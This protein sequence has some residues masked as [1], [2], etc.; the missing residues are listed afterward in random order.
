MPHDYARWKLPLIAQY[1]GLSHFL[2]TQSFQSGI[3]A[4]ELVSG[5]TLDIL[6]QRR[7][8]PYGLVVFN[9]AVN[10]TQIPNPPVLYGQG[11]AAGANATLISV[12][13]LALTF[14]DHIE[15][16]WHAG[17]YDI[18]L[19]K[20]LP[21]ILD[22]LRVVLKIERLILFG[23]SAG[24]FASLFYGHQMNN[25]LPIAANPQT[26]IAAFTPMRA[27]HD[28]AAAC[29]G[30][31]GLDDVGEYLS[32][33]ICTDVA[34]LYASM[35]KPF[36]YFQNRSDRHIAAQTF[37]FMRSLQ[38]LPQIQSGPV[39][40]GHMEFVDWGPGHAPPSKDVLVGI[41]KDAYAWAGTW[42]GDS[43]AKS[44]ALTA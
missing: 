3:H 15:M 10:R 24:G 18:R 36:L 12:S 40:S 32:R 23:S 43:A 35:P 38:T 8:S 28:Y 33:F 29:F 30:W 6:I 20:I 7:N 42:D 19:Q 13:D 11:I 4:T 16:G 26:R 27:V 41:L 5:H 44:V 39:G 25:V 17:S 1:G 2:N 21:L 22:H 9:A 14:G 31:N 37:S 34:P